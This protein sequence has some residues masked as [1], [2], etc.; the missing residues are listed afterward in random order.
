MH[1]SLQYIVQTLWD[2]KIH[3]MIPGE[4]NYI[5][6]KKQA[7]FLEEL[8]VKHTEHWSVF[9]IVCVC[10]CVCVCIPRTIR[11]VLLRSD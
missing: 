7:V 9:G 5:N 10:V 1:K 3:C 6:L 11:F 8:H 4:L 2:H